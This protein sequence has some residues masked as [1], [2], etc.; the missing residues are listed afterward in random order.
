MRPLDVLKVGRAA[1]H[2]IADIFSSLLLQSLKMTRP[3]PDSTQAPIPVAYE[4][5]NDVHDEEAPPPYTAEE[6]TGSI[7]QPRDT[8][9]T[10]ESSWIRDASLR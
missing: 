2:L 6:L 4:Y 5:D 1:V 7:P 8:K 9:A 10:S 3:R